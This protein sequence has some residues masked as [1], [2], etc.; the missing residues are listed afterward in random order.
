MANESGSRGPGIKIA[1]S[2]NE[3]APFIYFDGVATFGV[4]AGAIQL[5]LAANTI[6]PEGTGTRTDVLVAA[7]LRCSPTAAMVLRDAINRAL[8][9]AGVDQTIQPAPQ[10]KPH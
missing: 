5:E 2:S 10:S 7:H 4:Y 3:L 6:M 8:E 9:M 1:A